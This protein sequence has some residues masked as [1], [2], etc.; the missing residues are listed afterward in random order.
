MG[1]SSKKNKV[2]LAP[3]LPPDVD[4]EDIVVSDED[5]EF[6]EE[7]REHVHLITGLNR[8][9]LD[10]V[11]TRVPDHDE[12]K[13]ELLYEERERKR[14]AALALNPRDDDGLEVDPVDALP[15]KNLQGELLYRTGKITHHTHST[16]I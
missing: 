2:I 12:D 10:K 16:S 9:A 14:R 15:V 11:V 5:V 3:P 4:D 1:K 13:V 8:K 6:V 7:N